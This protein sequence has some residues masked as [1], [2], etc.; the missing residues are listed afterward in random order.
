MML[1][2][3]E[4]GALRSIVQREISSISA[5]NF[6]ALVETAAISNLLHDNSPGLLP[7]SW[8]SAASFGS[9]L[10]IAIEGLFTVFVCDKDALFYKIIIIGWLDSRRP[11]EC[12]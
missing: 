3:A 5:A 1:A 10:K 8:V 11:A 9:L 12:G 2:S 6:P 7:F 4:I